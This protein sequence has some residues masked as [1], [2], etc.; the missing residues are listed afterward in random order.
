MYK[1]ASRILDLES[2]LFQDADSYGP[3]ASPDS[4]S[5]SSYIYRSASVPRAHIQ[6]FPR[7]IYIDALD[8]HA[9]YVLYTPYEYQN[10][11][12]KDVLLYFWL[13]VIV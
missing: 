2:E 11:Y 13:F 1:L 5:V 10:E 8:A 3:H 12:Q 6:Q 4:S 9:V 7:A